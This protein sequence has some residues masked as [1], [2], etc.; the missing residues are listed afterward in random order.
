MEVAETKTLAWRR[1]AKDFETE[2]SARVKVFGNG[3]VV[4]EL[5]VK[6]FQISVF[7]VKKILP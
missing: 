4:M 1:V 5:E 7:Q 3:K 6:W 2:E